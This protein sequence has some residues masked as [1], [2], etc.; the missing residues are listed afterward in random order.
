VY[1]SGTRFFDVLHVQCVRLQRRRQR[2]IGEQFV[3]FVTVTRDINYDSERFAQRSPERWFGYCPQCNRDNGGNRNGG[4]QER[5]DGDIGLCHG[6]SQLGVR[7]VQDIRT[8]VGHELAQRDV[9]RRL[10]LRDLDVVDAQLHNFEF[11]ARCTVIT[12]HDYDD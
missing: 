4:V 3:V 1:R 2:T 5:L 10:Q 9:L 12:S 7:R 6:R 8:A 11:D